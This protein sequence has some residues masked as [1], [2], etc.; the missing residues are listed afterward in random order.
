[1]AVGPRSLGGSSV[2]CGRLGFGA[3]F[4]GDLFEGISDEAALESATAGESEARE[5]RMTSALA[6][7]V[8]AEIVD[9]SV[10][11]SADDGFVILA[12]RALGA[13]VCKTQR[14]AASVDSLFGRKDSVRLVRHSIEATKL[15]RRLIGAVR[16]LL[17]AGTGI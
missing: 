3:A 14:P 5:V 8:V 12:A 4:L 13:A 16:Q 2:R 10:V 9:V 11:G 6:S 15:A 17:E 1:M 7:A